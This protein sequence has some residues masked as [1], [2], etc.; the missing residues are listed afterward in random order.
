V[1]GVL[2]TFFLVSVVV[3][4]FITFGVIR[5]AEKKGVVAKP[6]RPRDIHK[7]PVPLWGGLAVFIS[8]V[9]MVWLGFFLAD[10]DGKIL[11]PVHYLIGILAGGLILIIFGMVDDKH[12]LKAHESIWG[13]ILA[14]IC[15]VVVG[16]RIEVLTNPFGGL[17]EFGAWPILGIVITFIWLIGLM[18]TTKLLDGLDGLASGITLIG[19]LVIFFL[20]ISNVYWQ[21]T[22]ALYALIFSGVLFGFLIWNFNP[23]RVF[24][25]EGGSTLVGFTLGV[26]AIISGAKV[27]T[28][29]LVM[30]I[31]VLDVIWV[32]IRRKFFEHKKVFQGDDKHLH[33]RLIKAGFSHK[34][35]VLFYYFIAAS[36][37]GASLFLQ[38]KQKMVALVLLALMMLALG[39]GV[40]RGKEIRN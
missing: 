37:G 21:P 12:K 15:V 30:G 20:S 6:T 35:A 36:F 3:S 33:F 8:L 4:F 11:I 28:A 26:L 19:A 22:V 29:L 38:S 17:L 25:G 24:L 2:I 32:M 9:I 40:T 27:A 23:A 16:I 34:Q 39:I 13:P 10:L 31:P 18:E 7:K 14:A 5:L 1:A